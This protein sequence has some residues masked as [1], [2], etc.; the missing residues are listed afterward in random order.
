MALAE[1]QQRDAR[2]AL[3]TNDGLWWGITNSTCKHGQTVVDGV[4]FGGVHWLILSGEEGPITEAIAKLD[5]VC[6]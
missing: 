2:F 4:D 1:V 6:F 3:R 5:D